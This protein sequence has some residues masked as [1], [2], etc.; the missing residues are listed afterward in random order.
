MIVAAAEEFWT[1]KAVGRRISSGRMPLTCTA[2]K[3]KPAPHFAV[4]PLACTIMPRRPA[5]SG[6]YG[7]GR[8]FMRRNI[9]AGLALLFWGAGLTASA[10]AQQPV[11]L[12]VLNDQTGL[13]AD[14]T[15]MG[16]V[17][18]ARMAVED[19]GGKVLGRPIEVIFADHQN[20]PDI[21]ASI[22][23]QWIENDAVNVILDLP[24]S[25]VGLAVREVTRTHDAVDIN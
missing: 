18:A 8:C 10:V 23:R 6:R 12:G 17:H 13:Y 15:G 25:A 11:K 16:S 24:N 20:K 3:Q 9:I 4:M 5:F 19:Y 2:R 1:M 22:A 21:G 7:K 14:L